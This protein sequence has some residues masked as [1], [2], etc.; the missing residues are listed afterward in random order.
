MHLGKKRKHEPL[1]NVHLFFSFWITF[2]IHDFTWSKTEM[3][4]KHWEK[5]SKNTVL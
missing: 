2:V 3:E 1:L 4:T 5:V